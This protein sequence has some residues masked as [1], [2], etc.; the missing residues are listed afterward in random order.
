MASNSSLGVPPSRLHCEVG[1]LALVLIVLRYVG[2]EFG[3]ALP[4]SES[5]VMSSYLEKAVSLRVG[6]AVFDR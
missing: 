4:A 3:G 2:Q 1:E 5:R 6:Q